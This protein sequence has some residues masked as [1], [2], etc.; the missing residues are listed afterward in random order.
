MQSSV[1]PAFLAIGIVVL[2]IEGDQV[3]QAEAVVGG[4]EVDGMRGRSIPPPLR[5]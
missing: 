3:D 2:I 5:S 1:L 4:H